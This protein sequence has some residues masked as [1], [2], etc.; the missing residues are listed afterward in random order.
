MKLTVLGSS[1]MGNSYILQNRKEA[2]IIEAGIKSKV[3]LQ[4]L[5]FNVPNVVGCLVTHE[6][7]DHAG[8]ATDVA[9]LHV[10]VFCSQGTLDAVKHRNEDAFAALSIS[11]L[12]KSVKAGEQFR[13]GGFTILPFNT[14]H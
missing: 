2:L 14:V 10:S 1:S 6:H 11:S 3:V 8:Y 7:Q 4:A 13:V 12:F 9:G 5:D